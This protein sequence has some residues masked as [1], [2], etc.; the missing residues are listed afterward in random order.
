MKENRLDLMN[1]ATPC[2]DGYCQTVLYVH[3][4]KIM[5]DILQCEIVAIWV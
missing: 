5:A 4:D 2:S 3:G 1:I